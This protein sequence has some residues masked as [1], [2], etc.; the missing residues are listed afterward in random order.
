[1]NILVLAAGMTSPNVTDGEYPLCLT[2]VDGVPLLERIC[3]ACEQLPSLGKVVITLRKEEIRK[4]FLDQM[5]PLMVA[6]GEPVLIQVPNHTQGATCTALL[7]SDHIDN[8]EPLLIL[9]SNELV[10]IDFAAVVNQFQQRG[11]DAGVVV[12]PSIHPR[13]CYVKLDEEGELLVESAEKKT[14]SRNAAVGFF[15]FAKGRDF[16]EAAKN[17]I[18]KHVTI[19]DTFYICSA[20][21]E[22]VLNRKKIGIHRIEARNYLP[23]KSERH[24][25]ALFEGAEEGRR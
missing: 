3:S 10:K 16:V 13:Y 4:F 14:I 15:W 6:K 1:M 7:A 5:V 9:N 8:A 12:F 19:N 21:N 24:F 22:L 17:T 18:R 11:L 2:E 20:L 23:L 25:Q